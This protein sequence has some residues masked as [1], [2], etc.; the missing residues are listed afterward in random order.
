MSDYCRGCHYDV[1]DATGERACPFNYLY[2]DFV[3]RHAARFARNPRMAMPLMGLRKMAPEKLGA[4]R[5][6]AAKFL[7][8]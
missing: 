2:W 4:M 8:A 6:Q 3:A 5:A 7:G 1:K